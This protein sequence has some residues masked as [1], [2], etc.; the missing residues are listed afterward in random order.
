MAFISNPAIFSQQMT[1]EDKAKGI[2]ND[3]L[4][5]VSHAVE[6]D[7]VCPFPVSSSSLSIAQLP[8]PLSS[9]GDGSVVK[10][11]LYI[12]EGLRSTPAT[13]VKRPVQ[14]YQSSAGKQSQGITGSY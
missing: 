12:N 14:A 6:I 4:E 5:F 9:L 3:K 13:H 2:G 10:R 11:L 1:L 8:M 7:G